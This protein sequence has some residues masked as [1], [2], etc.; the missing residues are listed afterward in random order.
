MCLLFVSPDAP[1]CGHCKKLAPI[2][3]ELGEKYKDS[4]DLI[5]A[6]MDATT[7]ELEDIKVQSFPAIR[8][9][10]KNSDEVFLSLSYNGWIVFVSVIHLWLL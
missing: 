1:W 7:N 3:D 6:K 2:W 5:V 9:F 4:P 8:Y 10:P